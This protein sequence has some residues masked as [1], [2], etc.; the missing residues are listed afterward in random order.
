M[1]ISFGPEQVKAQLERF[2]KL[3]KAYRLAAIPALPFAP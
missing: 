2:A 3:P 1:A